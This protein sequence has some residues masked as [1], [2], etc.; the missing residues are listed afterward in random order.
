MTGKSSFDNQTNNKP[1]LSILIPTKNREEYTLQVVNH[2][3][4]IKDNRF[5][6]VIQ[7]NSNTPK[8]ENL[9]AIYLED[10]RLKYSYHKGIL[11]FVDNFSLGISECNGEYVTIIGDDDSIN[12]QLID[13]A[14]YALK[15]EIEAV[16]PSLSLVYYW[17]K[18]SVS[19]DDNG[20]LNISDFSCRVKYCNPKK[21]IIKLLRNG[22]QNYLSY[23]LAKAYH[24]MVKRSILLEIEN[25]AGKFIG[26]LSPDI[27]LSIS[28]SLIV[29][30]LLVIDYPLTISGICHKSGSADSASG[31]HVGNLGQA[32][33]LNGH[34][35]YEWSDK[36][37][38]FYSVETIWGDSA[39]AALKELNVTGL[40]KYFS[41]DAI[42]A[43]CMKLYPEYKKIILENL[44]RNHKISKNSIL[45]RIFLLY[46]SLINQYT[47]L[48]NKIR[49]KIFYN[50]THMTYDNI[51]DIE[52]AGEI[53]L[54][55]IEKKTKLIFKNIE[56]I[57]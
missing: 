40:L 45:L 22:C 35:N 14:G 15:K 56:N 25:R 29:K 43:G 1:L 3:L 41:V 32:P 47:I 12:P 51:P 33:H 50:K 4:N 28:I 7:D 23:E 5:Q 57:N 10:T 18:S 42:S 53:I 46:G 8:L 19:T 52:A 24:G 9:L 2:I 27:Y 39:L 44:A 34:I 20:I 36:I 55:N 16:L 49:Y 6:L 26:G 37:P 17:P 30:R 13:I 31:K 11:S 21:E 38:S 48:I 54:R